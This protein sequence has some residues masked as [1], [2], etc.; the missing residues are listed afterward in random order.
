M[1]FLA[2][3][4]AI[5]FD[6]PWNVPIVRLQPGSRAP[7]SN[8]GDSFRPLSFEPSSSRINSPRLASRVGMGSCAWA[9][10]EGTGGLPGRER[11]RFSYW[12]AGF[13][14]LVGVE[15]L[16]HN[17]GSEG[18]VQSPCLPALGKHPIIEFLAFGNPA[19]CTMGFVWVDCDFCLLFH[20][21]FGWPPPCVRNVGWDDLS[22]LPQRMPRAAL[23]P[24]WQPIYLI[25][26]LRPYRPAN[27]AYHRCDG[28]KVLRPSPHEAPISAHAVTGQVDAVAVDVGIFF[29]QVSEE[30]VEVLGFPSAP[31]IGLPLGAR[32]LR[33]TTTQGSFSEFLNS[34]NDPSALAG[35]FSG[36]RSDRLPHGGKSIR[37]H[38]LSHFF[39]LD[40]MPS[41]AG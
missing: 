29:K 25:Q 15:P 30:E 10:S 27:S 37:G 6:P 32:V 39:F 2:R 7:L 18:R 26:G 35:D 36:L 24:G 17:Q 11:G 16:L 13:S 22:P 31:E 23:W 21:L 3:S 33:A 14:R 19:A 1:P 40:G 28:G 34:H 5:A 12:S 38:W 4:S 8:T 41:T 20:R 9:V